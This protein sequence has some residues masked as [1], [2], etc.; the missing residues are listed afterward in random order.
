[1]W[2]G[3]YS[4]QFDR[5]IPIIS[6]S[7]RCF[8][9]LTSVRTH[10]DSAELLTCAQATHTI[11]K[12]ITE[13]VNVSANENMITYWMTFHENL[14]NEWIWLESVGSVASVALKLVN[15]VSEDWH[16]FGYEIWMDSKIDIFWGLNRYVWICIWRMEIM[17][18]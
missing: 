6:T 18:A 15:I 5:L 1:M 12:A 3:N 14:N 13:W 11:G 17:L 8:F 4:D 16:R 10:K 2:I 7:M 9:C